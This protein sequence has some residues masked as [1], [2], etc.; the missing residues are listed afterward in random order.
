MSKGMISTEYGFE[1]G[2]FFFLGLNEN[3]FKALTTKLDKGTRLHFRLSSRIKRPRKSRE[4][5]NLSKTGFKE[6]NILKRILK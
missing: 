1:I 3:A 2:V 6:K 5:G 4:N